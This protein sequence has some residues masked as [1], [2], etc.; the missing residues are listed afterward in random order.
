MGRRRRRPERRRER[1]YTD[2]DTISSRRELE[3]YADSSGSPVASQLWERELI[4][5]DANGDIV[6]NPSKVSREVQ[7][8][9]QEVILSREY[10]LDEYEKEA[11]RAYNTTPKKA[12]NQ[13]SREL[14]A[15]AAAVQ[16]AARVGNV[17]ISA[18]DKRTVNAL[19]KG[20]FVSHTWGEKDG[21]GRRRFERGTLRNKVGLR[22]VKGYSSPEQEARAQEKR[23]Q[24]REYRYGDQRQYAAA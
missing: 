17:E 8:L 16:L 3:R 12:L 18:A 5:Y 6:V 14:A 15:R 10:D 21:S 19:S 2:A 4:R 20:E 11:A 1:Y 23:D 22:K 9:K 13:Q 7:S 24:L